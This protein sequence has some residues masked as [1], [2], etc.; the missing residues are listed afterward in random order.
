LVIIKSNLSHY[1][2]LDSNRITVRPVLDKNLT[3]DKKY[4]YK[5]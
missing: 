3:G 1:Y 4:K 2:K 5:K